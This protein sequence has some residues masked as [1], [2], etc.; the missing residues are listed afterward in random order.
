MTLVFWDAH[1]SSLYLSHKHKL[2][3]FFCLYLT[4]RPHFSTINGKLQI[5]SELP[6][7]VCRGK[8]SGKVHRPEFAL[9][10]FLFMGLTRARSPIDGSWSSRT[11]E[12]PLADSRPRE[13]QVCYAWATFFPLE[14]CW[15]CTPRIKRVENIPCFLLTLG[16]KGSQFRRPYRRRVQPRWKRGWGERDSIRKGEARVESTIEGSSERA[17]PRDDALIGWKLVLKTLDH[18]SGWSKSSLFHGDL[19]NWGVV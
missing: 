1:R 13:P 19:V 18:W 5:K 8:K 14:K 12:E 15:D 17:T 16:R 9:L 7:N 11:T 3:I 6:R 10:L 2:T 4:I